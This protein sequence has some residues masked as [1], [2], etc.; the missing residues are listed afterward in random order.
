MAQ[1]VSQVLTHWIVIYPV[2]NAIH[3][4]NN[5]GLVVILG[6]PPVTAKSFMFFFCTSF[7]LLI[8]SL[9]HSFMVFVVNTTDILAHV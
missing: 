4:L 8:V 5:P 3:L 7:L 2:D 6:I 9:F 1:L